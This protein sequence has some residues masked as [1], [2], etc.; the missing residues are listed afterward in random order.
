MAELD[1]ADVAAGLAEV[2]ADLAAVVAGLA[3]GAAGFAGVWA[4]AAI[5][6]AANNRIKTVCFMAFFDS[7][8]FSRE[9]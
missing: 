4:L 7:W 1:A 3:A 9:V 6:L 2:M 5:V 8:K